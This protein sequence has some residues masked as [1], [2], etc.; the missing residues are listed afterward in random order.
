MATLTGGNLLLNGDDGPGG[1]GSVIGGPPTIAPHDGFTISFAIGLQ[2]RQ[3]FE[4][5]VDAYGFD[6]DGSVRG[7]P[8]IQPDP[9]LNLSIDGTA[10]DMP[11]TTILQ[12]PIYLPLIER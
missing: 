5:Y 12:N 8:E 4:F 6:P 11:P 9:E 7:Q 1:V 3:A 2:Q 10:F